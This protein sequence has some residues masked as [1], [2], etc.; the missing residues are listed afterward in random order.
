M[1]F[2]SVLFNAR[3]HEKRSCFLGALCCILLITSCDF[4]CFGLQHAA[5]EYLQK[6][7]N[8]IRKIDESGSKMVPKPL[9]NRAWR[10]SGGHLGAIFEERWIQDGSSNASDKPRCAQTEPNMAQESGKTE[11]RWPSW[12]PRWSQDGPQRAKDEPQ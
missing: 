4:E 6:S 1:T 10:R 11:P 12:T 2:A 5:Q 9:Q 3:W 7:Q 8:Y